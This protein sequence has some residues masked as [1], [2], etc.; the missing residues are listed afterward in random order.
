MEIQNLYSLDIF[1][2]GAFLFICVALGLYIVF[3]DNLETFKE[4]YSLHKFSDDLHKLVLQLIGFLT[5]KSETGKPANFRFLGMIPFLIVASFILGIMGHGIA[6]SW[7]DSSNQNHLGLKPLWGTTP[8][9]YYLDLQQRLL[10]ESPR[11]PSKKEVGTA[12][13]T[14]VIHY[15]NYKDMLRYKSFEKVYSKPITVNNSRKVRQLY[16]EAKHAVLQNANYYNYMRRSQSLAEYS[17]IFALGFFFL[18]LCSFTNLVLMIIRVGSKKRVVEETDDSAEKQPK[19]GGLR[20]I[21]DISDGV[22]FIFNVLAVLAIMSFAKPNFGL[23]PKPWLAILLGILVYF[24]AVLFFLNLI[25]KYRKLRFSFFIYSIL[26]VVS[27]LGYFSSAK[28]W[29]SSETK[30]A[31]KVY[32]IYKSMHTSPEVEEIKYAQDSLHLNIFKVS[33]AMPMNTDSVQP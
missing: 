22:I 9:N 15:P 20:A 27:L 1:F 19:R 7:I 29:L 16:F 33:E 2:Q 28:L 26:F 18:F 13:E 10:K 21:V 3:K 8:I 12:A 4:V 25:A 11:T 23:V 24:G 32:G 17:R 5:L 31:T 14:G 30:V 6:D